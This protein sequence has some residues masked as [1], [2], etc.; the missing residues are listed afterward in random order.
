MKTTITLVPQPDINVHCTYCAHVHVYWLTIT[1]DCESD[2]VVL[3]LSDKH[4][5]EGHVEHHTLHQHPHE[6]HQE[7]VVQYNSNRLAHNLQRH[8]NK[9]IHLLVLSR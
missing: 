2:D 6:G 4:L 7:R 1:D 5:D 8:A 3:R 9:Y